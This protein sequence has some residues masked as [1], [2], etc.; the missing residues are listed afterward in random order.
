MKTI[1]YFI[2][3]SIMMFCLGFSYGKHIGYADGQKI[4]FKSGMETQR[5]TSEIGK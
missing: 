2:S 1:L 3:I 5:I 4:G